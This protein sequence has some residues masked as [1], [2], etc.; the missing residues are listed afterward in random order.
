[1][2]QIP[3]SAETEIFFV[4]VILVLHH[5]IGLSFIVNIAIDC[6]RRTQIRMPGLAC[7]HLIK[8]SFSC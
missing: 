7:F 1:M 4:F 5:L 3:V 2:N 8:K 6:S